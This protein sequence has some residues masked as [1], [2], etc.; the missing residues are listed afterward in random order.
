LKS[1]E[2]LNNEKYYKTRGIMAKPL[3]ALLFGAGARVGEAYGPYALANP[4]QIK[5]VAVAEPNLARRERFARDH[6]IPAD[7]CFESWKDALEGD[8]IADVVINCTQDQMHF[9]SSIAAF[10]TGYDMLL[11]KPIAHTLN[12]SIR[13]VQAAEYHGRYL[14]ICHVL[15]FTKFF[16]RIKDIVQEGKLGQIL[17]ISHR[18][19]VAS[20]HMA[21]SYVRGNWSQQEQSSPMLLAKCCHDLDLLVWFIGESVTSVSSYGSLGH[22]KPEN[23]PQ[24]APQR[25]TDGCPEEKTCP[26]FAPAIY[27]DLA[28]FK[29][30]LSQSK[31]PLLRI[32]ANLA[33]KYPALITN[34][35]KILPQLRELTEYK[36]LP[37]SAISDDP[38]NEEALLQALQEGQYG[39]CVYHCENDVVDHQVVAMEFEGGIT[40]TLT[41]HG[42]S[43]EEGR[44][45]RIDGSRASLLAK[46]AF[47]DS[48]IE[49]HDHRSMKIE[50][51]EFPIDLA[52]AGHGGG[53]YGIMRDF[54]SNVKKGNPP[55]TDAKE[56]LES[57]MMAFAAEESRQLGKK[58]SMPDF[59]EQ[60]AAKVISH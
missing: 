23:A 36:G 50:R 59:R 45:L 15:R 51:I 11:E 25:C 28:P 26:F 41:M 39:R 38:G 22:F 55:T 54:I 53:D 33:I 21:H 8:Q 47:L 31:N 4:D 7:R 43:H 24:G 5:F 10:Q 14:Q 20:W 3:T 48:Y 27:I 52:W 30:A 60:S 12:D 40:A 1:Q 18:E 29:F 17:T 46:F 6:T 57:H 37:R 13:I 56:S 16:Q 19:N 32:I 49:I 35:S 42:H 2:K 44:S 58:I 34:V 9:E